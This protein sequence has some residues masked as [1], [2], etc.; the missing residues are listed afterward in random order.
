MLSSFRQKF[1]IINHGIVD[2]IKKVF[3]IVKH[4]SVSVCF[5]GNDTG[6][7]KYT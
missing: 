1:I 7:Q 4:D 2:G 3:Y 5:L 6:V